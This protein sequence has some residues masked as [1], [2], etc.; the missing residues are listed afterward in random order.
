MA[1]N[2]DNI[3]IGSG[4]LVIGDR[5]LGYTRGGVTL[6]KSG[7]FLEVTP[8]Q[9]TYPIITQ[10]TTESYQISTELLEITLDNIKLAWGESADVESES[11]VLGAPTVDVS[12]FQ[13]VFNGIAPKTG[14]EY[15]ERTITFHRVVAM[16]YG[17]IGHTRDGESVI[18]VTF[19]ALYDETEECIGEI[20]DSVS[21]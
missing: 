17:D 18:P 12:E 3:L 1:A 4:T 11:L 10:K 8:D 21:S 15:G 19:T 5:D 9:V 7:D 16:E 2:K 13:L 20:E 14:G 6:A